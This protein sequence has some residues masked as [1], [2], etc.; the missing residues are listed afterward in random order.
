MKGHGIRLVLYQE[1]EGTVPLLEWFDGMPTKA[2]A[3]CQVRLER[4]REL[5]HELRRPEGDYLRDGIYEL[6]AKH[7]GVN[8]R[9]LYFFFAQEA[10]VVSHGILKQQAAVPPKEIDLAL[11]RKRRFEADPE[12]HT[13][14]EAF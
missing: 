14:K 6:R 2:R 7:R 12:R 10:V 1:E 5:G 4:L 3:K 8:Y 9:I 11:A 13:Y